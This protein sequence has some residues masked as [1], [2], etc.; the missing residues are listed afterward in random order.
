MGSLGVQL[1]F[2]DPESVFVDPESVFADPEAS[3]KHLKISDQNDARP[4]PAY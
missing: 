1:V 2:A 3:L 4:P